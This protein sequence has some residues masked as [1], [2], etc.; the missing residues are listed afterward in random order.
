LVNDGKRRAVGCYYEEIQDDYILAMNGK[1]GTVLIDCVDVGLPLGK[2]TKF[3]PNNPK[4]LMPKCPIKKIDKR[5]LP[6]DIGGGTNEEEVNAIIAAPKTQFTL[7]D[8]VTGE[9]YIVCMRDG[10]LVT[11]KAE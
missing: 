3:K 10:N 5:F 11:Y 1:R 4:V 8:Q 7:I 6:D 9:N 2:V